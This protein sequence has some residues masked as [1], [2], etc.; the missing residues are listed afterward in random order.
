MMEAEPGRMN[1]NSGP[2]CDI[3]CADGNLIRITVMAGGTGV[4]TG[5]LWKGMMLHQDQ[6]ILQKIQFH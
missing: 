2:H 5:D 1:M 4:M 6:G 3:H